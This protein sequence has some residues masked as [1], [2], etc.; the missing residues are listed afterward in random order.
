MR[1]IQKIDR[2][3][4]FVFIFQVL[5]STLKLVNGCNNVYVTNTNH[6]LLVDVHWNLQW[7]N[8]IY[9]HIHKAGHIKIVH[10]CKFICSNMIESTILELQA[11]QKELNMSRN[12]S[13]DD[14]SQVPSI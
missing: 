10:I 1:I 5:L 13:Q 14:I 3:Y 4:N 6:K 2:R 8:K 11:K 7:V 9:Y 12:F